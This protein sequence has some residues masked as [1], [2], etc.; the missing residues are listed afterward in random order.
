MEGF[1]EEGGARGGGVMVVLFAGGGIAHLH[2]WMEVSRLWSAALLR[3]VNRCPLD[4]IRMGRETSS[5]TA[6]TW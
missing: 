1:D 2:L 4:W 5:I 3:I 6:E